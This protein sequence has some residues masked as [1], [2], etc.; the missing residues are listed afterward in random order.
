MTSSRL[1]RQGLN[2]LHNGTK[3]H[4]DIKG[5]NILLT[6]SGD[7]KLGAPPW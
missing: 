5:G 2:Y 1:R 6:E 3:I 4:R 7:V